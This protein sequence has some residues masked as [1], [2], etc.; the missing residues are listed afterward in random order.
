M[1][2]YKKEFFVVDTAKTI[3]GYERCIFLESRFEIN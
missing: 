3:T 1:V 2:G